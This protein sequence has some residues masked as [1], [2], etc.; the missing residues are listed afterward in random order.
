MAGESRRADYLGAQVKSLHSD[1]AGV[2]PATEGRSSLGQTGEGEEWRGLKLPGQYL[3]SSLF[4]IQA[5]KL[6]GGYISE[7]QVTE[8][9]HSV[10]STRWGGCCAEQACNCW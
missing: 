6:Q 10:L 7:S 8:V 2:P 9:E 4:G 3:A 5:C 1:G